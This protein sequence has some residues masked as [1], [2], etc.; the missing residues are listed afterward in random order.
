VENTL[1]VVFDK[2]FEKVKWDVKLAKELYS[3]VVGFQNKNP[4]HMAFFGGVLTG[5]QRVR[6]TSTE[7]NH[8]YEKVFKIDVK[9][10]TK[11]F[12]VVE[13]IV[14]DRKIAGDLF[15]FVMVYAAHRFYTE[16]SSIKDAVRFKAVSDCIVVSSMR[17]CCALCIRDY[18]YLVPI[19]LAQRT[20]DRLSKRYILKEL[21]SWKAYFDYR[22]QK[23]LEKEYP[24][25]DTMLV[26]ADTQDV[27]DWV[28]DTH[29]RVKDTL[30]SIYSEMMLAHKE[31]DVTKQTSLTGT[32]MSGEE[33]IK[34]KLNGVG[35]YA[36]Y[37]ESIVGNKS[38]LIREKLLHI[39]ISQTPT[40]GSQELRD[41]LEWITE[42]AYTESNN[43]I[44]WLARTAITFSF[45]FLT[46][47]LNNDETTNSF[48]PLTEIKLLKGGLS[49]SRTTDQNT[50][51]LRDRGD[52][53]IM[54]AVNS[55]SSNQISAVR[56]S[57]IMYMFLRA[58]YGNEL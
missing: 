19:P 48:S 34:V 26:F 27:V 29:N 9:A 6:F 22:G 30:K 58:K 36:D 54:G 28:V 35:F 18:K 11:E 20:Y 31:K 37:M 7:F 45:N 51:E 1:K 5:V 21:G 55:H 42:S 47:T 13:G 33:V 53:V 49:S 15:N 43:D 4:D 17:S 46:R 40:V 38:E 24:H 3:F 8:L 25:I 2:A 56:N 41:V 50:L 39:A 57:V 44:M 52:M 14:E 16:K 10:L 23:V 32:D 12:L